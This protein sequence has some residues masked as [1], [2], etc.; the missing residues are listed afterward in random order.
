MQKF[1]LKFKDVNTVLKI[2]AQKGDC[3][4]VRPGAMVSMDDSFELKLN[5]GGAKNAFGRF[6]SGQGTFMQQYTALK[7][8][9]LILSPSF[10]GDILLIPLTIDKKYRLGQSAFLFSHG[11]IDMKVKSAGKKGLL[12]GEGIFQMEVF[13]E[14]ML[15]ICAYG[16]IYEKTLIEGQTYIVDTNQLVLWDS[17]MKYNVELISSGFTSLMGG[18]GYICKFTGPGKVLIQTKNPS[19][20]ASPTT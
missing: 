15:G 13:G 16:A 5:S 4:M 18:E 3:F 12:S 17:D 9:E 8:G 10:L 2:N 1:E 14:G 6:W 7:D 19:T 20:L 11:N